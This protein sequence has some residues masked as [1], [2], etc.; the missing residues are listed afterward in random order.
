M[1]LMERLGLGIGLA[2]VLLRLPA[3]F[4]PAGYVRAVRAT[5]IDKPLVTR[6][7]GALLL[8]CAV[9]IVALVAQTLTLFQAVML[10]VAVLFVAG[11]FAMLAFTDGYRAFAE[12]VLAAL[13]HVGVRVAG[14]LGVALGL[15][16]VVL[17]LSVR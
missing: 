7:V 11:G 12:R 16:I 3:I 14:A 17:S 13:P 10:I 15:W 1:T 6:A 5:V 8:G 4:W 9:T 2:I